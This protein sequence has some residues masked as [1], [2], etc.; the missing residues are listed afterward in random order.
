MHPKCAVF[1]LLLAT[2]A[3]GYGQSG[4]KP[5][6]PAAPPKA[7]TKTVTSTGTT[8]A[9]KSGSGAGSSGQGAMVFIDPATGQ[10]RQPEAGDVAALAPQTTAVQR[11]ASAVFQTA[12]GAVGVKLGDDFLN[13]V[14]VQKA[15]DGTLVISETSGAKAAETKAENSK[16][17]QGATPPKPAP[18]SKP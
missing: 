10:I 3:M 1:G 8:T 16:S 7:E 4:T 17:T 12:G 18:S 2:A 9:S 13:Y 5:T 14:T 6:T 11:S 15:A